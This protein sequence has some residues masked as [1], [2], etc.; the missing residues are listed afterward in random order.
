MLFLSV[1][2]GIGSVPGARQ[3]LN[4]GVFMTEQE[5]PCRT[6]ESPLEASN[7]LLFW[8]FSN[9]TWVNLSKWHSIFISQSEHLV[10]AVWGPW[11]FSE[12]RLRS[13]LQHGVSRHVIFFLW[14]VNNQFSAFQFCHRPGLHRLQEMDLPYANGIS[15]IIMV[16][17]EGRPLS[18]AWCFISVFFWGLWLCRT[19]WIKM[20]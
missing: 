20:T 11:S 6:R 1:F 19:Q 17:N 12:L 2:S 5:E 16:P 10:F 15:F 9:V 13:R 18:W 7:F 3:E 14:T 8:S 4:K